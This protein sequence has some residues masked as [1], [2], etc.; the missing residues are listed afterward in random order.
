MRRV[1]TTRFH[2]GPRRINTT[3]W[4][5]ARSYTPRRTAFGVLLSIATILLIIGVGTMVLWL[6]VNDP[7]ALRLALIVVG[8]VALGLMWKGQRR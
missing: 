5:F 1:H 4:E 7:D 8:V 2:I 3:N 6:I